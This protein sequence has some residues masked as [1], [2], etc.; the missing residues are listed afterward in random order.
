M[1]HAALTSQLLV[2]LSVLV[3]K[4]DQS[5]IQRL[6]RSML[7]A[8]R[9]A[10]PAGYHVVP[11][12][13]AGGYYAYAHADGS[14]VPAG[15]PQAIA[16]RA[17]DRFL[18]LDLCPDQVPGN[19]AI[20][21]DLRR[22]GVSL[23]FLVYDLLPLTL[24]AMFAAGAAPWFT[25]WLET[26]AG[27]ADSL[28]CISRAVAD[29]LL[30]W[31]EQAQ[32]HHPGTLRVAHFALGADLAADPATRQ[33][34]HAVLRPQEAQVLAQLDGATSFLM[35]GTLEPRKM[36]GQALDAFEH[37]WAAGSSACLVIAGKAGWMTEALVARLDG[38]AENGRRLFWLHHASDAALQ[39][40]YHGC[41]ALLAASAGEGFG[42]PLVEAARAGL[43]ILARDLPV[44]REVCGA[45]AHYFSGDA[46]ALAAA[47]QTWLQQHAAGQIPDAAAI[48]P[49]D[50]AESARQLGALL[51]AADAGRLAPTRWAPREILS[52]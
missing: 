19:R 34:A 38:H 42:L 37:L 33:P 23:H 20:F 14:G 9:A 6:V 31:L 29:E 50:W 24:P 51:L 48:Q 32:L 12:Y 25:R 39:R 2:D 5:G 1:P 43:P 26:V 27:V 7:H 13:D 44:F 18:G 17:G 35:V 52:K 8:L 46:G 16:V 21:A 4:D 41:S 40:L 47:V 22:H 11:V 15:A 36:H 28:L 3:H 49:P 45:H 10:P 30:V